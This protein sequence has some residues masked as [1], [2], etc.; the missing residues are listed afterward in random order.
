MAPRAD[1][2]TASQLRPVKITTE[3]VNTAPGAVL[4]E[5]GQTRVLCTVSL[6]ERVPPFLLGKGKGWLTAEYA[7]LPGSS[8]QRVSRESSTGR[9]N[10][11][12]REI[13]RLIGRSLRSAIDLQ[14]V[15]ERTLYVDCDVLQADGGTRT[16]SITG[17]W[18]ALVLAVRTLQ[19]RGL[20]QHDDVICAQIA[21][22]SAGIVGGEAML[23]LCY[24]EDSQADTDMNAVMTSDDGIIEIQATAER[25]PFS[26]EQTQALLDLTSAGIEQLIAAQRQA[27]GR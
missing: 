6:E 14:R 19:D 9:P 7:M 2:R 10:G 16:A 15:G 26:R 5:M 24:A 8:P 12:T 4:M 18:V 17:A 3:Y 21:A 25:A 22:V 13:Q 1:S 27:I 11:R 20:L 23:D